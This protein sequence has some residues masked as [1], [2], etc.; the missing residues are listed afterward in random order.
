[1]PH[2]QKVWSPGTL[3]G[4]PLLAVACVSRVRLFRV[5]RAPNGA[6]KA[7]AAVALHAA[8][9]DAR[10]LAFTPDGSQLVGGSSGGGLWR[11]PVPDE[12][13]FARAAADSAAASATAPRPLMLGLPGRPRLLQALPAT[14][15][16]AA[17]MA[18]V[19]DAGAARYQLGGAAAIDMDTLESRLAAMRAMDA[20]NDAQA[21]GDDD[22]ADA[23]AAADAA[24]T[25][26]PA[27]LP[28]IQPL[29]G[30]GDQSSCAWVKQCA[31]KVVLVSVP[32]LLT[33]HTISSPL[34]LSFISQRCCSCREHPRLRHAPCWPSCPLQ[35][36]PRPWLCTFS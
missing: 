13:T 30:N 31:G 9:A 26:Q 24:T 34:T 35:V 11:L 29:L 12:G 21:S 22:A 2:V 7:V 25:L 27:E 23:G 33:R 1:M 19:M 15:C 20:A 18:L 5:E 10:L 28:T 8:T 14:C 17:G 6:P 4:C 32:P 36:E 3:G 16:V